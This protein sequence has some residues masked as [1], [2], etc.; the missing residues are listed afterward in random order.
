MVVVSLS[1]VTNVSS[2]F[3]GG[4]TQSWSSPPNFFVVHHNGRLKAS[5]YLIVIFTTVV[6]TMGVCILVRVCLLRGGILGRARLLAWPSNYEYLPELPRSPGTAVLVGGNK[7]WGDGVIMGI[8]EH[9]S[10]KRRGNFSSSKQPL[11]R[12]RIFSKAHRQEGENGQSP[13]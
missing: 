3:L 4:S 7:E 9:A 1:K 11:E 12:E 10:T 2:F 13:L 8:I 6:S 5:L